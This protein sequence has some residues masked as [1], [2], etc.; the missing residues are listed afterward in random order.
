VEQG[1]RTPAA[2]PNSRFT[3]RP[4]GPAIASEWK[5]RGRTMTRSSSVVACEHGA[6]IFQSRDWDHGVFLGSIVSSETTAAAVGQVATFVATLCHAALLR[7]QHADY[8]AHWL[9][10][11]SA[12]TRR[13]SQDF[14]VNWF[15]KG[16]GRRW[17]WPG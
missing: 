3:R 9:T 4:S 15:R 13:T 7:V 17:L 14:Y 5:T 16:E 10:F 8:F 2:H 1:P 6:L 11:S 12:L